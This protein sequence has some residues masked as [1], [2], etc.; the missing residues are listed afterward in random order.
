MYAIY[1]VTR[2][3]PEIF[4][5][6]NFQN[7][8]LIGSKDIIFV[9]HYNICLSIQLDTYLSINYITFIYLTKSL[10]Q[11]KYLSLYLSI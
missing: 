9:I 1:L 10:S 8:F 5:N 7:T 6:E 4:N 3:T 2:A 11:V